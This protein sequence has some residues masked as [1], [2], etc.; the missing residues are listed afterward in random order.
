MTKV[1]IVLDQHEV[2][3]SFTALLT[4]LYLLCQILI[5]YAWLE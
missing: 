5:I 4:V 1:F 2:L 3:L